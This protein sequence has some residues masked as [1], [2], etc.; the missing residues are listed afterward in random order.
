MGPTIAATGAEGTPGR[1][2]SAETGGIPEAMTA[3]V[4]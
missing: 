2:A 3:R 1:R 4:S